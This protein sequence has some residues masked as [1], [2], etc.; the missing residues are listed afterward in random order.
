MTSKS[1]SPQI[2]VGCLQNLL[3]IDPEDEIS[4]S[5]HRH[6]LDGNYGGGGIRARYAPDARTL[7]RA[8]LDRA[9]LNSLVSDVA[10]C[11]VLGGKPTPK[12][13]N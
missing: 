1:G 3:G 10:F 9:L 13:R 11:R 5:A 6:G 4:A 2:G 12:S 7:A 8:L